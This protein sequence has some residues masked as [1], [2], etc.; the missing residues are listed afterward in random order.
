MEVSGLG[1]GIVAP[2]AIDRD[3]DQMG[4]E[5]LELRQQLIEDGQLIGADGAPVSRIEDEHHRVAAEPCRETVWSAVLRKVKS[6][7]VVPGCNGW[8]G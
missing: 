5:P 2:D 8:S 1:E 7:A 6:G 4:F 3:T